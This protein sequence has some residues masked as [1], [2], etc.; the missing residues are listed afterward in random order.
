MNVIDYILTTYYGIKEVEGQGYSPTIL[1]WIQKYYPH[2]KDDSVIPNCSICL[3]E[4][5]KEA[6]EEELVKNATPAAISWADIG[7]EI[8]LEEA[9]MGDIVVLKRQGG[10]H[11]GLFIRY[12]SVQK[13][14]YILG[15]NQG[16]QC[17]ITAYKD[18]LL[19]TVRRYANN[20]QSIR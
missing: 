4:V 10:H 5:F 18:N 16:N 15:F 14:I 13:N 3:I 9:K 20:Y 7:E 2:V 11:V 17:N 8:F 12:S 19:L 6:G 1:K